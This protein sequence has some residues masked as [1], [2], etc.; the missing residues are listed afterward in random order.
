MFYFETLVKKSKTNVVY[1]KNKE[2]LAEYLNIPRPSLSRAL[3][4][5]K[6]LKMIDINGKY[7]TINK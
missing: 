4:E 3:I 2:R 7:I 1:I 5:L 6:D